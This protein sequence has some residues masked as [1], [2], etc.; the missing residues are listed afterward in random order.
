MAKRIDF[1]KI[2]Q[3][4]DMPHLTDIQTKSYEEFLQLGVPKSRRKNAGLEEVFRE[5]FPI[6]SYDGK[7]KL[8][9]V[10]YSYGKP[11]YTLEECYKKGMTYSVTLK[12]RLRLKSNKET[13]EQEIYLG[14]LPL[15]TEHGTFVIN[16]DE[17]VIVIML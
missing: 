11:K 13:K 2:R 16:G 1:G 17:R 4:C 3:I 12:V 14:D 5:V 10:S 8:D 9:Y 7:H 6:E 15:M